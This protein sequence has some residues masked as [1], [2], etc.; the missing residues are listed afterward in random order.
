MTRP[1]G[2][3]VLINSEDPFERGQQRGAA[4]RGTLREG[5]NVYL[6]LFETV[7]VD[8]E[9]VRRQAE[10]AV[11]VTE[12]WHA[13]LAEE[14]RGTAE[15]AGLEVWQIAALNARTEILSGATRGDSTGSDV[16]RP[17]EC[18]TIVSTVQSP[19]GVQT[20]DWHEELADCWHLQS[21]RG[22]PRAFVGLTEHGILGKIGI[23]DAGVG[24]MLN[25]LGHRSD[26][27][28]GVPVHLLCARVLAEAS[29]LAEAIDILRSAPV[30]TSSTISVVSPEEAA[31]V[32]L[33]PDGSAVLRPRDGVLLHTNHFLDARLAAGEKPGMYEPD[34][35]HRLDVLAAR[36]ASATMPVATAELVPYLLSAP[37][38][39]AQLCCVPA[40]GAVFGDRWATLATIEL[41]AEAHAMTVTAGSPVDVVAGAESVRLVAQSGSSTDTTP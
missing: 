7:G 39:V 3:V 16:T 13:P 37:G 15:G 5:I 1:V 24:V 17:G 20:W 31:M 26:R 41:D 6:D 10:N 28:E 18:S 25:I 38:D 29:S 27:V 36:V 32:E 34:S 9:T 14:M 4:I 12:G 11:S 21:V 35:Q 2:D 8:R 30:T 22:T 40:P 19:V 23:N 33:S